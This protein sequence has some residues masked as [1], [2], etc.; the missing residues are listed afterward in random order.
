MKLSS[1]D[2]NP[3]SCPPHPTRTYICEMTI[4][5]KVHSGII[6]SLKSCFQ[7]FSMVCI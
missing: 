7:L 5:P 4:A 6:L 2:L 1:K 3:D